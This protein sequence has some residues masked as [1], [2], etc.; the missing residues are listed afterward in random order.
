MFNGLVVNP[1]YSAI[2]ETLNITA[3]ARQRGT[4]YTNPNRSQSNKAIQYV[5]GN[6][7]DAGPNW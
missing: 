1:A 3:L 6:N 5:G 4:E 7:F 2:D